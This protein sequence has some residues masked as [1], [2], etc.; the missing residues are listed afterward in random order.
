MTDL[1]RNEARLRK[2]RVENDSRTRKSSHLDTDAALGKH[3][4][5]ADEET[6]GATNALEAPPPPP[7]MA[8]DRK[9]DRK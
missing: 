2:K 9:Y 4:V 1:K 7:E 5:A 8:K 3:P 6:E